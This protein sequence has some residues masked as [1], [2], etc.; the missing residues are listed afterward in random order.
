LAG[1]L[2]LAPLGAAFIYSMNYSLGFML[3][4]ALHFTIATKQPAMTASRIAAS[5]SEAQK[6]QKLDGLADLCVNVFRTQFIAIIGN[7][8]LSIP[9]AY[10]I[11][12][13]WW[14]ATGEHLAN[15]EK[16][17]HLIHELNPVASLAIFH[18]GIAGVCLFLSGLISGY[19][20]NKCLYNRIPERLQQHR[21]LQRILGQERLDRFSAY[22]GINLGA[23]AGNFY[24]GLM[25][26]SMGT[27]G[28][29]LG[30]PL[31]IRHITF[32]S[33]YFSFALVGSDHQL[34]LYTI[35]ISLLGVAAIGMTNLVVSFSLA[36]MVALKSRRVRYTQWWPLA[37]MIAGRFIHK[38]GSFFWPPRNGADAAG[39][40][41]GH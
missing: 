9:T 34:P 39:D 15:A 6:E 1:K 2:A 32:S 40:P 27:I 23:L 14:F 24:F 4:H 33:A 38:P 29:I 3:V 12:W 21:F 26:G 11:A 10:A 13:L 35:V 37:G 31:D 36:M 30:L 8:A 22:I 19:Y 25:L 7:V 41:G 16:S 5:I 17:A 20:D 28:F 18:A